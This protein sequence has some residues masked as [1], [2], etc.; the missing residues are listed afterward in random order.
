MGST[1]PFSQ[2]VG[3]MI[4]SKCGQLYSWSLAFEVIHF[5]TKTINCYLSLQNDML[6]LGLWDAGMYS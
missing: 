3:E 2:V 5:I 4:P 1:E 6:M